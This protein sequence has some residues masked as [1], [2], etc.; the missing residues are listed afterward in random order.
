MLKI[1]YFLTSNAENILAH[2][3]SGNKLSHNIALW[4]WIKI[5]MW[6]R[7]VS[8]TLEINQKRVSSLKQRQWTQF[9]T[10]RGKQLVRG[11]WCGVKI[12]NNLLGNF[13]GL[14]STVLFRK[15]WVSNDGK[16]YLFAK[17]GWFL[18]QLNGFKMRAWKF[19]V[20]SLARGRNNSRNMMGKWLT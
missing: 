15:G 19:A 6:T 14:L 12:K 1:L 18:R 3:S 4:A 10:T 11:Q 16:K 17:L 9:T 5:N 13:W 2:K 7:E 20:Q 8:R